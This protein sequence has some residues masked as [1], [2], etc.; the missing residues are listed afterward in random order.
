MAGKRTYLDWNATAP[1]R[2]SARAGALA[3]LSG[4]GNPSS[5]HA[6]GRRARALIDEARDKVARL[7]GAAPAE[8]VF[9]SGATEANNTVL[10]AGWEA[11]VLSPTEHDSVLAA[12]RASGA[13]LHYLP[14]DGQGVVQPEGLASCLQGLAG[15]RALLSLQMANNESGVLQPLAALAA[16]AKRR[17][18]R[19][20]S[21]AVQGAGRLAIDVAALNLDY[22]SLSAH[23]IGGLAGSGA[24]IARRGAELAPLLSG[25]GQER[26]RRAGTE[27]VAGIAGFGAAAAAAGEE[28]GESGR[29]RCLRDRLEGEVRAMAPEAVILGAGAE[30]LPNTTCLAVPGTRAETLVIALDLEGIAIGAGAA[31]SSGK[32]ASSHVL[33][34]MAVA[35]EIAVAAIRISLGATTSEDD[36][37]RFLAAFYKAALSNA[38]RLVA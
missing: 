37:D 15:E 33:A 14:V 7:V 19:V 35:P 9:T 34:A 13:R 23:K 6:E 30:R 4:A 17:G 24:L 29:V 38:R 11:I 2:G 3:A 28:V 8:V 5:P 22:L 25:G 18:L 16:M 10:G 27:N 12:A 36:I 31:C 1:L 20:H 26:R 32:V 21:D